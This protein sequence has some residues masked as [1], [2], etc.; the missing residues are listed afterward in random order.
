MA[1]EISGLSASS[2]E[3]SSKISAIIAKSLT[4]VERGKELVEKTNKTI[5]E[6][7]GYSADNTKM[8]D[9][10]VSFVDAQRDSAEDILK[11]IRAIGEMV[12]NNAA[13]AEENSAISTNLGECA[14]SLMDMV[15]QFKLRK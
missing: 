14:Q 15:A 1:E 12:E 10:I 11:S 5:S 9:E 6:S 13:S 3:S 8:V 7:A 4:S 2:S